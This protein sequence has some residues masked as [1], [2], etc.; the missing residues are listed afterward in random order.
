MNRRERRKIEKDLGLIKHKQS[1]SVEK[2]LKY[3]QDGVETGKSRDA[4]AQANRKK[5]ENEAD[6]QRAAQEIASLATTLMI[7]DGLSWYEAVEA[8]KREIELRNLPKE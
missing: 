2:R 7:R 3:L 6:D 8:A 5:Q 1:L 4:E